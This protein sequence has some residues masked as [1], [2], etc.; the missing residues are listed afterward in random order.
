M[1]WYVCPNGLIQARD[2]PK[3][4]GLITFNNE[5]GFWRTTTERVAVKLHREKITVSQELKILKS[6][7]WKYWNSH[8]REVK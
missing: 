6:L 8:L 5:K 4:S 3:Y 1:F 7:Y 2:I